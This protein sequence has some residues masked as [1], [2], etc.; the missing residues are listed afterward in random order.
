MGRKPETMDRFCNTKRLTDLSIAIKGAGE[1]ASGVACSLHKGNFR[2]IFMM[3]TASPLAVRRTVSFC[4]SIHSDSITIEGIKGAIARDEA[5]VY[6]SWD[7]NAVAVIT[8]PD[9]K[10]ISRIKPDVVID[11]TLAKVNLGTRIDEAPLVIGLGPGFEAGTDVHL[12]IETHRGHD[13]G[14]IIEQG[15]AHPNTGVPGEIGGYTSERV[16][17]APCDGRF[18]SHLEIG[19]PVKENQ[20]IGKVENRAVNA[21]LTGVLRGLIRPG[22]DVKQGLKIGDID[23]RGKVEYCYT[24]SD[25]AR[26]VGGS[27]LQAILFKL[28]RTGSPTSSLADAIGLSGRGVISL[29]GAGGKTSLM[30]KLAKE[31]AGAGLSVLTTTTTKIFFPDKAQ[32]PHTVAVVSDEDLLVDIKAAIESFPHITAGIKKDQDSGKLIGLRPE[33]VDRI[34]KEGL[35]D[36][37][38]VEADGSRQLPLKASADHEPVLPSTTSHL[39]HVT[40]LDAIGQPIDKAVQRP[41]LFVQQWALEPGTVLTESHLANSI[42]REMQKAEGLCRPLVN[43]VILNKADTI[44]EEI[45]GKGVADLLKGHPFLHHLAVL[46]L[47]QANPVKSSARIAS[48]GTES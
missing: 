8:D 6:I 44:K 47:N 1:M 48:K 12:V 17:R 36:V 33:S 5:D 10:S 9:W 31:L 41:E 46:A 40:G 28:N 43:S 19:D 18:E 7:R 34:W 24:V 45:R 4:E 26:T 35:F 27:V 29:I 23:P 3:D 15:E 11:A 22:T 2:K 42:L 20:P 32:S 13:I 39:V 38:I 30:F 37:I 21:T 14:R 16:L 25:K